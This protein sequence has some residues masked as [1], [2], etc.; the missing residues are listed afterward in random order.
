MYKLKFIIPIYLLFIQAKAIKTGQAKKT[1]VE[2]EES[3]GMK[4]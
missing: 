2:K 1:K 3:K 4:I